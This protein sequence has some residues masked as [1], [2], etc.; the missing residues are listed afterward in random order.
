MSISL[1]KAQAND[2][3][4]GLENLNICD[5]VLCLIMSSESQYI[6]QPKCG[7]Q[8]GKKK[9]TLQRLIAKL[10]QK[11]SYLCWRENLEMVLKNTYTGKNTVSLV[12]ECN[13]D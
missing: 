5:N 4:S 1:K 11:Y 3:F 13:S 2:L 6:S 10:I 9:K 12:R 7:I 8:A